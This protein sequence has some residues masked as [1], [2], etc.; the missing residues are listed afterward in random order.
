M[1]SA[2]TATLRVHRLNLLQHL[3][4]TAAREADVEQEN[5]RRLHSEQ[6]EQGFSAGHIIEHFEIPEGF[7]DL[8]EA[9]ANDV[10]V[11]TQDDGLLFH[12]LKFTPG[13]SEASSI[14][15]DVPPRAGC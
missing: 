13:R 3:Q 11:V 8:A 5:V 14:T 9:G 12:G 6:G 1:L 4:S 15:M 7:D 2:S 10:V